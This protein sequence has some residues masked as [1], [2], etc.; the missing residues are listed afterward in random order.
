MSGPR[1]CHILCLLHLSIGPEFDKIGPAGEAGNVQ[2]P[3]GLPH[4]P[5]KNA[6]SLNSI[7]DFHDYFVKM[8]TGA[9]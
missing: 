5:F 2:M 4:L 8:I 3:L 6:S 7:A 9:W 1:N